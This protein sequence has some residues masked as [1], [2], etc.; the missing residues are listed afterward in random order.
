M[1]DL[2]SSSVS[3]RLDTP[4]QVVN[5]GVG[6]HGLREPVERWRLP[7]LHSVHL[8]GYHA[9]VVVDGVA[10]PIRPGSLSIIAAGSAMEFR[11]PG[12][13]EHVFAH[14]RLP[15]SGR[16]VA[17]PVMQELGD[18]AAAI[19][20]RL[21]AVIMAAPAQQSAELWSIL[22]RAVARS[23]RPDPGAG[24]DHPAVR[25]A[26][27]Y[28]EANLARPVRAEDVARAAHVSASHLN[29]LFQGRFGAGVGGYLR[30]RRSD[31]VRH[32]LTETTQS[33]ISI[34]ASIG[35]ADLQNFNNFCHAWLGDSPRRIRERSFEDYETGEVRATSS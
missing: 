32:L 6:V 26:V 31:Q 34:A 2:D 27:A 12:P 9:E 28:I 3:L 10:H 8:Y 35:I 15:D 7:E 1:S 17:A 22:W 24:G 11:Y 30:R 13:S 25:D 33:I 29:R 14:L 18:E 19:R 21:T 5:V 23:G 16:S 20:A 4:P